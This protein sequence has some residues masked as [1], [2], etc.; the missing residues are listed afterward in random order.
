MGQAKIFDGMTETERNSIFECFSVNTRRFLAGE[1]ILTYSEQLNNV[2]VV[3]SGSAHVYSID[4]DGNSSVIE[5]LRKND[6]FGEVF[7]FPLKGM[8]Y[9]A[10]ADEDC[11]IMFISYEHIIHPCSKAC[12]KHT[13]L[14]NNLFA[15]TAEKLQTL[16]LRINIL[17][18]KN[19]RQKLLAFLDYAG[20]SAK[21][22]KFSAGMS[23]TEL[24]AYLNVDRSSLMREMKRMKDEGII[25]SEGRWFKLLEQ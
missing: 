20:R 15:L 21:G 24:A 22:E 18:Q 11:E 25:W 10:E 2:C 8:E 1:R 9:I 7:H 16:E 14:I 3:L 19:V 6:V 13:L 5:F 4:E 23:I 12:M 17:A